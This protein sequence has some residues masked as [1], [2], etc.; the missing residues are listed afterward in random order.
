MQTSPTR[1]TKPLNVWLV[2]I[3]G[4]GI[5]LVSIGINFSSLPGLFE[6]IKN[7]GT[8]QDIYHDAGVVIFVSSEAAQKGVSVGDKVLNPEDDT[9][10]EIG[11]PV[12]LKIQAKDGSVRDVQ[13]VRKV[14]DS[15]AY[16]GTLLGLSTKNSITIQLALISIPLIFASIISLLIY[17]LRS[18]DWMAVLTA[19]MI[20]SIANVGVSINLFVSIFS[21]VT[22][23]LFFF[24]VYSFSKR[25]IFAS[26]V[27]GT[28]FA[29]ANN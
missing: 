5:I 7:Q 10:G 9:L 19:V 23:A 6:D 11:T 29:L 16:G 2:R 27:M 17:W 3:L 14:F 26:L 20:S 15:P 1:L 22:T 4:L 12:T 24:L 18:D 28:C 25:E 21:V 13:L 8:T